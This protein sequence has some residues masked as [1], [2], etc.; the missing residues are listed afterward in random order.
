MTNRKYSRFVAISKK[1]SI[2]ISVCL[3]LALMFPFFDFSKSQIKLDIKSSDAPTI[4]NRS[5]VSHP[6]FYGI[7]ENDNKYEIIAARA[8]EEIQDKISLDHPIANIL[9][10][11]NIE[12]QI[13]SN[14]GIWQQIEKVLEINQD[15]NI[16]YNKNYKAYTKSAIFD[17]ENNLIIGA[18]EINISGDL[19]KLKANGFRANTL[20]KKIYFTGPVAVIIKKQN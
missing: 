9:F 3:L 13:N 4:D 2:V 14:K 12:L 20:D 5:M 7:D 16:I 10:K 15:V 17:V 8:L 6:K 11:D 1:L 18:D 19:G